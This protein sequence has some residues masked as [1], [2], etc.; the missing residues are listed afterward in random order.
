MLAFSALDLA[1]AQFAFTMAFHILFPA[2]SIGLAS[3]LAVLELSWLRTK[4]QVYVD[5][6][7][8]WLKIFAV[9]FGMGVVSGIVMAY[10][11]GAG[12]TELLTPTNGSLMAILL[13]AGVPFSR[14]LRFAAAGVGLVAL[15]AIAG[16]IAIAR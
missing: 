12:L 4:R 16:L 13:A 6:Y 5:L 7:H 1:R 8:F 11:I 10:Q 9:M 15:V 2:V 14:W 3:Y